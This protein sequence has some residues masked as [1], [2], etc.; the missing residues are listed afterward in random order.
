MSGDKRPAQ[1]G[2]GSTTQLVK[3]QKPE[4]TNTS[5]A[6]VTSSSQNGTLVQAVSDC[7]GWKIRATSQWLQFWWAKDALTRCTGSS[8]KWAR[9]SDYGA[10]R[11]VEL[12]T[13][14]I[15]SID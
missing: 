11:L 1:E 6:V 12:A 5:S 15:I 8:N 7:T 2:F 10:D 4:T 13:L 14:G 9:R 3:R